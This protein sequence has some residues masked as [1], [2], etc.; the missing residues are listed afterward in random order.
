MKDLRSFSIKRVAKRMNAINMTVR[1]KNKRPFPKIK[2]KMLSWY[3]YQ[4]RFVKISKEGYFN[5]ARLVSS[6]IDFSFIRNLVAS[7]YSKEGAPCY[8]PCSIFLLDLFRWIEGF[9]SMAKFC[10]LL[11]HKYNGSSYRLYAGISEEHIPCEADFSNF[12]MR[13]GEARYMAIFAVLVEIVRMLGLITGRILSHDGTLV[14]TFA[15]Y[16]GCNYACCDCNHIRLKGDFIQKTR[17]KILKLLENPSSV[18]FDKERRSFA[19]CP[20]RHLL[21]PEAKRLSMCVMAFKLVP[22]DTEALKESD[23]QTTKLFGLEEALS[24]A[25]LMIKPVRSNISKIDLN[26]VDNP[27][28][29]RC[30]RMPKDLDAKVGYRR[31]KY[32]PNKKEKVFGYQVTITTSIELETGLELPCMCITGPGS[33]HD[34]NHF[35]PAKEL[36]KH[37]HPLFK[38]KIDIGDA[39]FDDT[40]NY[41]YCRNNES[42]PIFDYNS[43]GEDLSKEA[44]YKRGYD[45]NGCPFGPCGCVCR[46]N[47]YDFKLKRASYVCGKQCLEFPGSIPQPLV[48]CPHLGKPLGWSTH[49]PTSKN[50]RLFTEIPRGSSRWKT[51]RNLRSSSERTNSTAKSDL[52]ILDRPH[53]LGLQRAKILGQINGI[54]SL[55]KKVICFVIKVTTTIWRAHATNKLKYY[56]QLQLLK[57]N[58]S[59]LSVVQRK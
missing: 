38:T 40:E 18:R 4:L 30:P 54:M 55:L 16:R 33:E 5:R 1:L 12:R 59:I 21:P 36:I 48:N 17:N 57:V 58:P 8:D 13:L 27:V 42:I 52:E 10:N 49:I 19:K 53:I 24:K 26:L 56:N 14:P 15:R 50:R 11:H 28:Y 43:R 51:I 45:Q 34:G 20:R 2:D 9:S 46:S 31:S 23:D 44:L 41:E 3:T 6:L 29:V 39:G 35:I 37:Y 32:N 7:C 22:L 47:G 25:K